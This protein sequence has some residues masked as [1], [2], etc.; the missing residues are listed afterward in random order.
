M[1]MFAEV[2]QSPTKYRRG[3]LTD[4]ILTRCQQ[5]IADVC[6]NFGAQLRAFN[7]EDDRSTCSCTT[8]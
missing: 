3:A 7:G 8:R 1:R 5:I 6:T 4:S 2:A